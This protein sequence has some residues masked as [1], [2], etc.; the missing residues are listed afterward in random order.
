MLNSQVPPKEFQTVEGFIHPFI[1]GYLSSLCHPSSFLQKSHSPSYM[2]VQITS[3]MGL[4]PICLSSTVALLAQVSA[5]FLRSILKSRRQGPT[6]SD[7]GQ[8]APKIWKDVVP[9]SPVLIL[10]SQIVFILL[11]PQGVLQ[12][13]GSED[14]DKKL[15]VT[16]HS[17]FSHR[18]SP[19]VIIRSEEGVSRTKMRLIRGIL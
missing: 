1:Q 16:M 14:S 10:H 17:S 18:N 4:K 8:A 7:R 6:T 2:T 13:Q 3:S 19:G 15:I 9:D 11:I 12:T 5:I